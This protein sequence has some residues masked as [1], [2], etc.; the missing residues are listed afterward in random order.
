[1]RKWL[2]LAL[3]LIAYGAS[4]VVWSRLPDELPVHWNA[5]GE[6]DRIGSKFEGALLLPTA[7]LLMFGLFR[8]F[9]RID[10]RR[11]NYAKFTDTYEWV[12]V[13]IIGFIV[14]LHLLLLASAMGVPIALDRAFPALFGLLIIG[15]GNLLPRARS[16]WWFGFRT[17]WTLSDEYV[18]AR[19]HR[20]GGYAMMLGGAT[21]LVSAL[22]PSV[23]PLQVAIG[24][25]VAAGLFP[26]VYS[27]FL[28]R[29]RRA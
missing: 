13:L 16:N 18:W 25:A 27:Y 23:L 9:P 22:A 21:L 11:A 5:S 10:P 14:A 17:P 20:V 4:A 28:W 19:T 3:I 26:V 1:M 8:V 12:I 2:P 24:L 7:A 15:I 29:S 6:A